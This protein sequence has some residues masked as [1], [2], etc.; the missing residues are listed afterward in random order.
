MYPA[1][2]APC[3]RAEIPR[4]EARGG[5]RVPRPLSWRGGAARGGAREAMRGRQ[6]VA[7]SATC[8][9]VGRSRGEDNRSVSKCQYFQWNPIIECRGGRGRNLVHTLITNTSEWYVCR[10][11]SVS[12]GQKDEASRTYI[13]CA[14]RPGKQGRSLVCVR[15][16][17]FGDWI[18]ASREWSAP[19]TRPAARGIGNSTRGAATHWVP[20]TTYSIYHARTPCRTCPWRCQCPF[21]ALVTNALAAKK[22]V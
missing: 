20:P 13:H 17:P 14:Y 6:R 19:P 18:R 10:S 12:T 15:C 4:V 5:G 21:V 1:G 7:S 3:L 2:S 8:K 22:T 16:A 11:H 9:S